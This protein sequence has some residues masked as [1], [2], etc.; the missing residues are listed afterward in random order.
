MHYEIKLWELEKMLRNLGGAGWPAT[1][2]CAKQR[3]LSDRIVML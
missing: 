3:P 1:W 2:P